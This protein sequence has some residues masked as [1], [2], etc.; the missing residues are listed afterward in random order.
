M[1]KGK[2][3]RYSSCK[4]FKVIAK[5]YIQN[6]HRNQHTLYTYALYIMLNVHIQKPTDG[7][8]EQ[9]TTQSSEAEPH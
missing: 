8:M 9:L 3:K 6:I 4:K 2:C 1:L 7:P 5:R